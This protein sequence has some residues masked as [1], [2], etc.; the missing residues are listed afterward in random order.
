MGY[1][2]TAE[3]APY[4]PDE[5]GSDTSSQGSKRVPGGPMGHAR[6]GSATGYSHTNSEGTTRTIGKGGRASYTP[7]G[8]VNEHGYGRDGG[9]ASFA[10][11]P[12]VQVGGSFE[13]GK[14]PALP[15]TLRIGDDKNVSTPV[16]GG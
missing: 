3:T 14:V 7:S 5:G 16:S 6:T 10:N 9:K 15:G 2:T 4:T 11:P 13:V 12:S 1:K 8:S